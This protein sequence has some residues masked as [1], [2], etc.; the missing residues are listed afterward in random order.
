MLKVVSL[1]VSCIERPLQ[2]LYQPGRY[3]SMVEH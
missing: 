2:T 1:W 3:K